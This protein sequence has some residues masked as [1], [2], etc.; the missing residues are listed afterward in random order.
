MNKNVWMILLGAMGQM[1][2]PSSHGELLISEV[3]YDAPDND[4]SQEWVEIFN[5]SCQNVNL[6]DYS[7]QDNGGAYPLS[8][9]IGAGAYVSVAKNAA[10]FQGLFGMNPTLSGMSLSLGNSGD[11]VKLM[12]GTQE[13]DMV[14]WEGAVSQWYLNAQNVSL[15]RFASDDTDTQQDWVAAATAGAPGV[16]DLDAG[17]DGSD[18]G[19]GDDS[20]STATLVNGVAKTGLAGAAGSK[21]FYVGS[22][23]AGAVSLK[24]EQSG[25]K[26]D[27]D[28]FVRFGAAPTSSV[29]DCR[30]YAGGNNETCE[31]K[32]PAAGDYHVMVS[33]YSDYSGL[34]LRMSYSAD[35]GG[36]DGNDDVDGYYSSAM[37]KTGAALKSALN[38]ILRNHT[39]MS[40]SQVWDALKYTDED[41]DDSS[42][43][44][45][46]YSGRSIDKDDNAGQSNSGDAWNRE[47][48]WPKS[49]GFSSSSQYAH[50][51]IHHLRPADVSIN[52][53]RGNKDFDLGGSA[54][55][56]APEN[57]T[58]ADSFEPRDAVKGDVARMIFYMDVRY[59]GGDDSGTPNLQLVNY[60]GTGTNDPKLG[61]LCQLLQWHNQDP[62]DAWEKRRNQRIYERQGNRNPFIDN[63]GWAQEIYAASC[64]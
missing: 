33:G 19:P 62:V 9:V 3:L 64:Q 37:G 6:A 51:D 40:Y 41:P 2:C 7:L 61:K 57:K 4:A 56:E 29:Y 44:M 60:S 27:A 12:K 23:P 35:S 28:L 5:P 1:I 36:D 52:S 26:G 48:V 13:V 46:L 17:C 53:A 54:I 18:Q 43:V 63:P 50:T 15:M 11:F 49:H 42:H 8:G 21:T 45:L 47:H 32:G 34:S 25:G 10:G 58:D 31:F 55:G 59:E 24:F 30:P 16:G 39:A 38:G 22:V 14:A 20:S